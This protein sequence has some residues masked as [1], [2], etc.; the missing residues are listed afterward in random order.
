GGLILEGN[1]TLTEVR[2]QP[3]TGRE[4]E[5]LAEHA[6]VPSA[7]KVTHLLASCLVGADGVAV[8]SDLVRKLLVGDRDYL[9]LQLRRLTLGDVFQAVI[10]C[11]ACGAKIDVTFEAKDVP[12]E[13]HPQTAPSYALNL[14]HP[15][16][17]GRTVRFRLPT[18]ADQESMSTANCQDAN[19]LL[20]RCVLDDG[21]V[22]LQSDERE[23]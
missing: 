23:M 19:A 16:P 10:V 17:S 4:E 3:L 1:H 12:V 8:T 7:M 15:Q 5:W 18:G 21:G 22:P 14:E 11:R 9:M 20:N 6:G 2:M 13:R